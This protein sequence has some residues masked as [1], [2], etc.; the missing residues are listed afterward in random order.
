[1]WVGAMPTDGIYPY[2]SLIASTYWFAYFLVILPLLGVFEKPLPQPATIEEDCHTMPIRPSERKELTEMFRKIAISAVSALA[3]TTG[4]MFASEGGGHV[5]DVAFSFEGPFGS[6][7]AHQLQRGL[8]VYTEVCAAC[9]GMRPVPLRS[10]SDEGG[11]HLPEDQVRAY[12]KQ[13][14]VTDKDTGEDREGP[15]TDN[16]P[17]IRVRAR[18]RPIADGKGP[19]RFPRPLWPGLQPA[20]AR[21]RR[22]GIYRVA[23]ARLYR[24]RERSSGLD[25]LRKTPSSRP[26]GSRCRRRLPMVR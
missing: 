3:L 21:Y 26:A 15:P 4:A 5:E 19:R 16:F 10:L 2:I 9:H 11:P 6:Y 1:M 22:T 24:R 18:A 12:A 25:L 23:A 20:D 17:P 7:D 13:F 8:Q 14:T